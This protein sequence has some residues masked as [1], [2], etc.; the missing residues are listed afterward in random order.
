VSLV[1]GMLPFRFIRREMT[2]EDD[3]EKDRLKLS[4]SSETLIRG[5]T[6]QCRKGDVLCASYQKSGT[7]WCQQIVHQLRSN[8][9]MNF[10]DIHRAV[11]YID[12]AYD[13]G[14]DLTSNQEE[15]FAPPR[16][17]KTH[18]SWEMVPKT[19]STDGELNGRYLYITRDSHDVACSSYEY[20]S[21][22]IFSSDEILPSQYAQIWPLPYSSHPARNIGP[23]EHVAGWYRAAQ[24]YPEKILFLFYEDLQADL[25][26][27]VREI[28]NFIGLAVCDDFE[29]KIKVAV[30]QSSF[31]FMKKYN[32]L[33][34]KECSS[35]KK[36]YRFRNKDRTNQGIVGR[37][38][39]FFGVEGSK[40]LDDIL[41]I[42]FN[43]QFGDSVSTYSEFKKL[44]KENLN[45]HLFRPNHL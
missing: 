19:K 17:F 36:H 35:I 34:N 13:L 38:R 6:F 4:S 20:Y 15:L 12:G 3:Q 39:E 5:L 29:E 2:T 32:D 16:A 1:A 33:Y 37:G 44:A 23:I 9:D 42:H 31:H 22:V 14:L 28:A 21:D 41:K 25:A 26:G 11:P 7:T 24:S 30:E 10:T 45:L 40:K 43:K 27:A 8:G 18:Y